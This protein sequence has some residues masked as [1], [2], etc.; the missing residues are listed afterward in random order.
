MDR[1]IAELLAPYEEQLAQA[2]SMS[3]WGRRAALDV[4]AGTGTGMSRFPTG[5]HLASW[6]GRTPLDKQS[7]A[8]TGQRRHKRGNRYV[9]AILGENSS[10]RR[11]DPAE[12]L[13]RAAVAPRHAV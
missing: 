3:G 12:G 4:T 7:G 11:E 8:R 2:E 13:P 9:T 10:R 1:L 5:S 6:C